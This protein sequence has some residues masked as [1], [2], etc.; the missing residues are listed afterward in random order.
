ME[1]YR[2]TI[3]RT[4]IVQDLC[5]RRTSAADE[6]HR[7]VIDEPS[8]PLLADVDPRLGFTFICCLSFTYCVTFYSQRQRIAHRHAQKSPKHDCLLIKG[9]PSAFCL[10]TA[11]TLTSPDNLDRPTR[12][13]GSKYVSV[14]R[15]CALVLENRS[16]WPLFRDH[17]LN[18]YCLHRIKHLHFFGTK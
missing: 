2:C 6:R 12:T 10:F 11:V 18:F 5:Q 9:V 17:A 1:F 14:L 7:R 15:F 8:P 13:K 3:G 4:C 16:F